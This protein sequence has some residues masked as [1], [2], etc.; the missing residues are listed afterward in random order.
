M[1]IETL[2]A[3]KN[4]NEKISEQ[5]NKLRNLDDGFGIAI[6]W[7][8]NF[9]QVQG[10]ITAETISACKALIYQSVK[11]ELERLEKEFEAL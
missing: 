8:G 10:N 9:N 6:I 4:L 11:A 7:K 3:A 2:N 5:K 1:D